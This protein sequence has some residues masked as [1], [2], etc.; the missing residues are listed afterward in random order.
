VP[1]HGG[2]W[3][4]TGDV[5]EL[6]ADGYVV[7]LALLVEA[8]VVGYTLEEHVRC[9]RNNS[10]HTALLPTTQRV[11]GICCLHFQPHLLKNTLRLSVEH[12]YIYI[13]DRKK[14]LII[15]G[16]ENIACSEVESAFYTHPAVLECAAFGLKDNRLG[17]VIT[18][19]GC[20][21]DQV[22]LE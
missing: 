12:R 1:G 22:A 8:G 16:G 11:V 10:L 9:H 20:L 3:F 18:F 4:R 21:G 17:A 19:G 2:G 7:V 13:V 5:A 14:D 6:D 15:R